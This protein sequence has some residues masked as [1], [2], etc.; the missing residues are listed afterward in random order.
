MDLGLSR[1][2]SMAQFDQLVI[3]AVILVPDGNLVDRGNECTTTL[4]QIMAYFGAT[5]CK[6]VHPMLSYAMTHII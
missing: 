3:V 4:P 5:V 2:V 1:P 6:T